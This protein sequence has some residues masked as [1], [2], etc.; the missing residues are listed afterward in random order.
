M[1]LSVDWTS[2]FFF[3]GR[4]GNTGALLLLSIDCA[5]TGLGGTTGVVMVELSF[6]NKFVG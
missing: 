6:Q 4:G 2:N 1:S 3:S 5:L